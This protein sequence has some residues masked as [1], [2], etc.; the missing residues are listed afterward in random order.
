[1]NQEI[2]CAGCDGFEFDGFE[3]DGFEFD[4]DFC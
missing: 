1:M 2:V 4:S 3:F